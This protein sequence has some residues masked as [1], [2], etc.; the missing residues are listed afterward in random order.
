MCS[1]DISLLLKSDYKS[2]VV[3][4]LPKVGPKVESKVSF[5]THFWK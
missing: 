1:T 5:L 2:T 4:F 3:A